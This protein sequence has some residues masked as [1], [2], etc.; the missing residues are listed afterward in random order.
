MAGV[1]IISPDVRAQIA[2]AM[3]GD[4]M[5][6]LSAMASRAFDLVHTCVNGLGGYGGENMPLAGVGI[7]AVVLAFMMFRM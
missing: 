6:Q 1:S 3:A 4:S 2:A 7:L 5:G